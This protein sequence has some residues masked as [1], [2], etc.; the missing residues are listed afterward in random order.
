MS[1]AHLLGLTIIFGSDLVYTGVYCLQQSDLDG[2]VAVFPTSS[3]DIHALGIMFV[4]GWPNS[5]KTYE[6]EPDSTSVTGN[7]S[8]VLLGDDGL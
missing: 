3:T 7:Q 8:R 4:N 2:P 5:I 6:T 1:I